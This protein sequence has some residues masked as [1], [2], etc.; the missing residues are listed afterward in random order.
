MVAGDKNDGTQ[1]NR[2][3]CKFS[4]FDFD[5]ARASHCSVLLTVKR[6]QLEVGAGDDGYFGHAISFLLKQIYFQQTNFNWE[7]KDKV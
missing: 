4:T 1:L 2:I 5:E 7:E 6:F 3:G